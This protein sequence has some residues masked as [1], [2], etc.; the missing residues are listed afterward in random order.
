MKSLTQSIFLEGGGHAVLLL[1]GLSSSPLEMRYLGRFLH[2][3]GFTVCAPVLNGYSAGTGGETMEHWLD[4]ATSE[5]DALAARFDRVSICGLS[6]GAA[7]ALA[8]AHRRPQAQAV[9]L[10]SLTLAYNGHSL[11]PLSPRMGLLHALTLALALPRIGTLWPAQRSAACKN[12]ALNAALEF[13]RSR[14]F[15]NCIAGVA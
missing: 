10:L 11:V 3:E 7:L 9:V 2:D 14:S 4:A 1:H 5:F 13:Q 15:D 12:R 8:L 6:I